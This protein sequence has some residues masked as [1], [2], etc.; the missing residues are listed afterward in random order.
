MLA[1]MSNTLIKADDVISNDADVYRAAIKAFDDVAEALAAEADLEHIL[2]LVATKICR[3][4]DIRR[5]S[6]YLKDPESGL[7]RGYV[8]ADPQ[9]DAAIRRTVAGVVADQFT[10]EIV[11][12]REPVL[13]RDA[14]NDP[15]PIQSTMRSWNIRAMLGVPM[16]ASGEVIGICYADNEADPHPFAPEQEEVAFA[17]AS[18]AAIAIVQ[19][20]LQEKRRLAAEVV[21]Q[22][23]KILR[24]TREID[25]Q[26]T[27][28]VLEG[29]DLVRIATVVAELT[30]RPCAIYDARRRRLASDSTQDGQERKTILDVGR[31]ARPAVVAELKKL[32]SKQV[33]VIRALPDEGVSHRGLTVPIVVGADHWGHL[34]LIEHGKRFGDLD[35]IV[36]TRAASIVA[37]QL[38]AGRRA[39]EA[40]GEAVDTLAIDLIRGHGSSSLEQRATFLGVRLDGRHCVV[41]IAATGMESQTLTVRDVRAAFENADPTVDVL[42][43]SVAEGVVVIL[44]LPSSTMEDGST[45]LVR[46]LVQRA[47][48]HLTAN[49]R[50]FAGISSSWLTMAEI[51]RGY[52]E[53]RQVSALVQRF[54]PADQN[55]I[56]AVDDLGVGGL[57]LASANRGEVDR[58]VNRLLGVLIESDD[59]RTNDL[60]TTMQSFLNNSLNIRQ[61]ARTLFVHENTIRYRFNRIKELTGLDVM[62]SVD[63]Q[64]AAQL[65]LMVLR[66]E[67]RL[68]SPPRTDPFHLPAV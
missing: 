6:V 35:P 4:C 12:T 24:R 13:V 56:V 65:A 10:Q 26:L 45:S 22:Q 2:H 21:D 17:F 18:L 37:V 55:S 66:L 31:S 48:D 28:L 5:C 29:A 39:V 62:S 57:L 15:R 20:Q 52:Q 33:E 54:A 16:L 11:E 34:V 67:G 58:Y 32:S 49:G 43:T 46:D 50:V 9:F 19:A 14:F 53:V 25:D 64:L 8:H 1:S 44:Q 63:D 42:T 61:T 36:A 68:A 30:R 41:L 38:A 47:S 7:F 40:R 60:L 59:S 27:R 23:N 3:L 51:R